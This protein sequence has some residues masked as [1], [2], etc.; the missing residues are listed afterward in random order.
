MIRTQ[1][2]EPIAGSGLTELIG[3][4]EQVDQ[5]EYSASVA[6][7][8]GIDDLPSSG[9]ILSLVLVSIET[10]SGAVLTPAGNLI[11]LDADPEAAAGDT[12]LSAAEWQTVLGIVTIEAADWISDT[13]GAAVFKQIAIP[14]HHLTSLY[15]VWDHTDATSYNDAAGDDEEL[16]LNLWYRRDS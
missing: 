7:D 16:H 15:A 9:E 11:L 6:L 5:N 8:V 2:F 14:F 4:D 13:G 10:G 12:A 3:K 1:P